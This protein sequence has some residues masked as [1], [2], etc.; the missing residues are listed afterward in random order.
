VPVVELPPAIPLT[1]QVTAVLVEVV[2]LARLTVAVKSV[3]VPGATLAADGVIETE[4][5]VAPLPP[6]PDMKTIPAK[7]ID[8]KMIDKGSEPDFRSSKNTPA[9]THLLDIV[10]WSP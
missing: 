8:R 6:Q 1:S 9:T 7:I 3:C 4:L 5:T 10:A 2:A